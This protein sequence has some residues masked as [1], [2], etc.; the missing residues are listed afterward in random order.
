MNAR[1]TAK[2]LKA[3]PAFASAPRPIAQNSASC[4]GSDNDAIAAAKSIL[5]KECGHV[6]ITVQQAQDV[7]RWARRG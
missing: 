4:T 5:F 2:L 1:L 7:C 6:E 3:V